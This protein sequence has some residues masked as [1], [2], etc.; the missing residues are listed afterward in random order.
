[1]GLPGHH[2]NADQDTMV[3]PDNCHSP[4][5]PL[6]D[7]DMFYWLAKDCVPAGVTLM[8]GLCCPAGSRAGD[9]EPGLVGSGVLVQK[10]AEH[11]RPAS[12]DSDPGPG[13]IHIEG[14]QGSQA[15]VAL[16]H[17]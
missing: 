6:W 11:I 15:W 13:H 8:Q 9:Q 17:L 16:V 3:A 12:F 1:M 14:H 10:G 7:G 2:L 5:P 4:V